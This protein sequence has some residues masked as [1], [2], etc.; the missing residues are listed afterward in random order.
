MKFHIVSHGNISA[1]IRRIIELRHEFHI[2]ICINDVG[3][4]D[5]FPHWNWKK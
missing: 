5:I 3:P 2:V 1:E 4:Y